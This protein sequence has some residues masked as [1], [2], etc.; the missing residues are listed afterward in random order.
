MGTR[1][2]RGLTAVL[3]V[4]ASVGAVLAAEEPAASATAIRY[5]LAQ[6]GPVS[7]A[8]YDSGGHMV[9]TLLNAESQA[10][11]SH[12]VAWDGLDMDGNAVPPGSYVWR[13]IQS[14]GIKAEYLM[15]IGTSVGPKQWSCQHGGPG[16][17]AVDGEAFVMGAG[18]EGSPNVVKASFAGDVVWQ[19]GQLAPENVVDL[20]LDGGRVYELTT[21][22]S[23]NV[24]DAASGDWVRRPDGGGPLRIGRLWLPMRKLDPIALNADQ[25]DPKANKPARE[26]QVPVP[27]GDYALRLKARLSADCSDKTA[28][29][30]KIGHRW[31]GI[32]EQ[33]LKPGETREFFAPLVYGQVA[34][35][36]VSG[37]NLPLSVSFTD[38]DGGQWAIEEMD[39]LAP[40]N[41][42]TA[43]DGVLAACYPSARAVAWLDANTGEV[44]TTVSLG[45]VQPADVA[46]ASKDELLVAVG[47]EIIRIRRGSPKPEP[48]ITGLTDANRVQVDVGAGRIFVYSAGPRQQVLVFDLA[49]KPL[50]AFGREGGRKAGLYK[51]EDFLAVSDICGDGTGGFVVTEWES[52]PRRTARFD[53]EG[54][55][56]REWYGGQQFYTFGAP[57]PDDPNM[58]WMDS[59]WGWLMQVEVDYAKRTWRPRACYQWAKELPGG[60]IRSDKMAQRMFPFRADLDGDGSKE[61]YIWSQAHNGLI[62]KVDEEAGRLHPI[63]AL[64]NVQNR[65]RVP[66]S[67]MPPPWVEALEMI[68]PGLS[69]QYGRRGYTGF[70]WADANGDYQMQG[71]E[72]RLLTPAVHKNGHGFPGGPRCL[73]LDTDDFRIFTAGRSYQTR[74]PVG[75]TPTGA[76]IWDWASPTESGPPLGFRYRGCRGMR[77]DREK[78]VY[79]LL[80]GGGDDYAAGLDP[81]HSHGANWPGTLTDRTRIVKISPQAG[82]LWQV[83]PHAVHYETPRGQV[84]FPMHVA[85]FAKGC[86]GITDYFVNPCHFWTEDGLFVGELFDGRVDDG[87]P[88]GVYSWWRADRRKG[89]H[90]DNWRNMALCQYD[91]AVGGSLVELPDGDVVFMGA[92][93]NNMPTYKVHGL[94]KLRRQQG[95]VQVATPAAAAA[96]EGTGLAGEYF[97]NGE[98]QGEPEARQ[99]AA[100]IWFDAKHPWPVAAIAEKGG[101]ARW[102]GSIEARF[103]EDYT[104]AVYVKGGVRLWVNDRLVLDEWG[105]TRARKHYTAPI[106]LAAGSRSPVRLEWRSPQGAGEMHLSWQSLT[107]PIE[108]IPTAYLYAETGGPATRPGEPKRAQAE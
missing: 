31:F 65:D 107:Q 15:S 89:D 26:W 69:E 36:T 1:S 96:G 22:C 95:T 101:S 105:E 16:A 11:G 75:R 74:S 67:T 30:M 104:F 85:G 14:E 60:M 17:V 103:S 50:A 34:P 21:G 63:A 18:V 49:G 3:L 47:T 12:T 48:V 23:I 28:F 93:W 99:A 4:A 39:L 52:A 32:T 9:R 7:L 106:R 68:E 2:I 43:R 64:G 83:G 45:D 82:V 73:W 76:P 6:D 19:S 91:M 100:M 59:Q 97:V 84:H 72:I 27:D 51:A 78:N 33:R 66:A 62:L 20:A 80:D 102:T 38:P 35:V 90:D 5:E 81:F 25:S 86:V 53:A 77:L 40:A 87:L 58:V 54:K 55:L 29:G 70:G 92:G 8:V 71:S 98:L 10:K 88:K 56:L 44:L 46:L 79:M 41:R 42:I 24:V 37:G 94:D 57:E 61:L 108:H 13:L